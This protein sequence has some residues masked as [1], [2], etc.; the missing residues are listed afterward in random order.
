MT[1]PFQIDLCY[2][3][4]KAANTNSTSESR[5]MAIRVV[6]IVPVRVVEIVPVRVV[7]L[8]VVE[9]VPVLVVEIVPALVVEIVPVFPK[10]VAET[11]P[12]NSVAQ[13]TN[14]M[15]FITLLLRIEVRVHGSALVSVTRPF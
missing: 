7:P 2:Q 14:L 5:S 10:A 13:M 9:I 3:G 15:V 8:T 4:R 12:S 1:D 6:E 11:A